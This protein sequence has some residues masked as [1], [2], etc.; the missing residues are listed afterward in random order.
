MSLKPNESGRC[1]NN[2]RSFFHRFADEEDFTDYSDDT[3][4]A[5]FAAAGASP[6]WLLGLA[7]DQSLPALA[8][9]ELAASSRH[10]YRK[11]IFTGLVASKRSP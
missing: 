1:N 3:N 5:D 10:D 8:T 7:D 2:D 11:L 9:D 4:P 6:N